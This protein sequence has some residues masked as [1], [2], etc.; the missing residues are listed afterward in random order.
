[1]YCTAP[2][3]FA[4]KGDT[5]VS[6][7]APVGDINMASEKCCIG[8]GLSAVR[9]KKG[10]RSYTYH[11]LQSLS[12][13]FDDYEAG[14]TVFGCINKDDFQKIKHVIPHHCTLERFEE[15]VSHLDQQIENNHLEMTSLVT[16]RDTLL[17]KLLS[18]EIDMNKDIH[19]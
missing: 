7:R 16:I 14:G 13:I 4:E 9:H 8:R 2:A 15:I 11:T 3:R 12:E 1:V 5:L 19:I 6:V 10:N 17:P 18:G